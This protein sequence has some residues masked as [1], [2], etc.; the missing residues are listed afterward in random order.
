VLA[1]DPGGAERLEETFRLHNRREARW[2]A[3]LEPE[4]L[5]MLNSLL[6]KLASAAHTQGWVSHRR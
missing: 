6:R 2:A 3:L 4:E 5:A 1:L